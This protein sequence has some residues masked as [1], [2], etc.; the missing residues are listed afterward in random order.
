MAGMPIDEVVMMLAPFGS[1]GMA[2]GKPEQRENVNGKGLLKLFAGEVCNIRNGNL[3]PATS[4]I[5]SSPPNALCTR[6]PANGEFL[7]A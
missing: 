2:L 6:E 1:R 4:A 7:I 5:I 3:F